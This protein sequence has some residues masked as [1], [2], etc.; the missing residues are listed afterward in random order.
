MRLHYLVKVKMRVL[1]KIL[2][3]EKQNSTNFTYWLWFQLLKKMQLSEFDDT[4]W[5]I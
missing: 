4:L 5:Q 1:V 3:L 2:M